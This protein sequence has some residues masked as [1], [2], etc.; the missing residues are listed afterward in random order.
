[1]GEAVFWY[2]AQLPE[3]IDGHPMY[4]IYRDG[5]DGVETVAY[6]FSAQDR[7]RIVLRCSR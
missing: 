2:G 3:D 5:P 1:M 4:A 7:D 6:V